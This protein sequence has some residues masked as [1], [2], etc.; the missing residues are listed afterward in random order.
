M[1][2]IWIHG[3]A[4]QAMKLKLLDYGRAVHRSYWEKLYAADAAIK[5]TSPIE[6]VPL[7]TDKFGRVTMGFWSVMRI[8]GQLL[9]DGEPNRMFENHVLYYGSTTLPN[10]EPTEAGLM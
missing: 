1:S 4:N 5:G 8:F 9:G 6:Y 3:N 10:A 7:K 2:G